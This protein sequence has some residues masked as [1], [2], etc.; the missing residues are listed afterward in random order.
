V[1]VHPQKKEI[2]LQDEASLKYGLRTA[3][4]A[5]LSGGKTC[6]MPAIELPRSFSF[7]T[8][9]AIFPLRLEERCVDIEEEILS[10]GLYEKWLL[11]D[12]KSLPQM[13]VEGILFVDLSY[14]EAHL[15]KQ[16]LNK[17]K[18]LQT[19]ILPFTFSCSKAES[20]HLTQKFEELKE[21][22]VQMRSLSQTSFIIDALS[23][24]LEER[25][26]S[27]IVEELLLEHRPIDALFRAVRRRKKRYALHEAVYLFKQLLKTEDPCYLLGKAIYP[28]KRDVIENKCAK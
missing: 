9:E 13:G 3:V 15:F 17:E 14:L 7:P 8:Q 11:I 19:L 23:N 24:Q 2:R 1:N 10:I 28:L 12:G 22:G 6:M 20:D 25:D 26:A 18:T 21:L 4:V 5:A 16:S 27:A